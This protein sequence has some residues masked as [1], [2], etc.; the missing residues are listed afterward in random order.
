[1]RTNSN[2]KPQAASPQATLFVVSA[3][4]FLTPFLASSVS[5]ALPMIGREFEAGA[6]QLGFIQLIYILAVSALLL[7]L[8]RFADIYG[9]K[10]VFL[11]GIFLITAATTLITWSVNIE[12]FIIFRFFQGAGAAMINSTSIAI[13]TS[14]FSPEKRGKA[15][16]FIIAFVYIGLAAGPLLSGFLI[17]QLGWRWVFYAIIPLQIAALLLTIFYLPGE[18]FGEKHAAFDLYGSMVYMLSLSGMVIGVSMLGKLDYSMMLAVFGTAG[19]VFFLYLQ[20]KNPSPLIDIN[21]LKNNPV[22]AWNS[23]ATLINY[24]ASFGVVFLFSLHLQEVIGLTAQQ[25]GFVLIAQP[26]VQAVTAPM[27]GKLSDRY[28]PAIIATSGMFLCTIGLAMAALITAETGIWQIIAILVCMGLGF[29]FF[30]SPNM[31]MIM[32]SVEKKIYGVA[33]SFIATMRTLGML[34]SMTIIT[35]IIGK[36]MGNQTISAANSQGFIQAMRIAFAIFTVMGM[37]G[38]IFSLGKKG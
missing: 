32:G 21:L 28:T 13:L 36:I 12:L 8:G 20:G 19:M 14:V 24:A 31:L 17:T 26:L 23:L 35:L 4:Q 9:R 33:S 22:F 3:V 37:A 16:G 18:W 2:T 38:C 11:T 34:V 10:K 29:G 6:A 30:S 25:A 27:A 1:M 5:V 7:P 15:M